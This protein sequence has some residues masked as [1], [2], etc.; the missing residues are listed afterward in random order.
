[1]F[2]YLDPF[3]ASNEEEAGKKRSWLMFASTRSAITIQWQIGTLEHSLQT[4]TFN[5]GVICLLFMESLL[6][7]KQICN[8]DNN[9]L[10]DYRSKLFDIILKYQKL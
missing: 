8:F 2:Y 3:Q 7:N 5:C 6:L 1:M 4:D 10:I 9:L